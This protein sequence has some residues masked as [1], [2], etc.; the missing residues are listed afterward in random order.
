MGVKSLLNELLS[1][2]RWVLI[3]IVNQC[4]MICWCLGHDLCMLF[5][6]IAPI[7][8]RSSL[9]RVPFQMAFLFVFARGEGATLKISAW[10]RYRD[11]FPMIF[12]SLEHNSMQ[13]HRWFLRAVKDVFLIGLAQAGGAVGGELWRLREKVW[14]WNVLRLKGLHCARLVLS[15][16]NV[17]KK[18]G[19]QSRA[20]NDCH[21]SNVLVISVRP[22]AEG[23]SGTLVW[24]V[25]KGRHRPRST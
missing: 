15:G 10:T 5:K 19:M 13:P 3:R 21:A 17:V 6:S 18:P 4:S 20:K 2:S 22:K 25:A 14:G 9:F 1:I 11:K 16:T 7:M 12:R 23:R 24:R 8:K